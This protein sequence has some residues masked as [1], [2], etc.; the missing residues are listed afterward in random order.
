MTFGYS[1]FIIKGDKVTGVMRIETKKT[2]VTYYSVRNVTGTKKG[3]QLLLHTTIADT[4]D[5]E[6]VGESGDEIWMLDGDVLTS[7]SENIVGMQKKVVCD[8]N[9]QFKV[10]IAESKASK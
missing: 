6:A 4:H 1:N 8:P 10:E 3:N 7:E 5:G 9:T 2:S